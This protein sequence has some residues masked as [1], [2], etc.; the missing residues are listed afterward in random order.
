M[1][2][3]GSINLEKLH[4]VKRKMNGKDGKPID[5]IILPIKAN[6]FYVGEKST[7][8]NFKIVEKYIEFKNGDSSDGFLVHERPVKTILGEDKKWS[9]MTQEEK[10]KVNDERPILGNFR[11]FSNGGQSYSDAPSI[12]EDDDDEIDFQSCIGGDCVQN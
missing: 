1:S 3:L 9:D 4:H 10:D 2:K 11:D 12:E 7:M 8:M 6:G 5:V